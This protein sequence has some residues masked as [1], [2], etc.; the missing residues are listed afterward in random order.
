M[1]QGRWVAQAESGEMIREVGGE[2]EQL[3]REP[4][5]EIQTLSV[6]EG[7]HGF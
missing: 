7:R 6:D 1:E 5:T 4:G 3:S 2:A